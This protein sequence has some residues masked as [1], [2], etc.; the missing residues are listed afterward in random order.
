MQNIYDQEKFFEGYKNLRKN[1]LG[2]NQAL[3]QPALLSLIDTFSNK[4]V[5]DIGCGFGDFCRY[6]R[7]QGAS[8]VLGID[9]SQNMIQDAISN[10]H[11]SATHYECAPIETYQANPRQFDLIISSLALHYV[12]DLA[13]VFKKI[14]SWLKQDGL[15]IFSVEHPI[16]TQ[17]NSNL[18]YRDEGLFTQNWF[19]D[20]VEKYHRTLSTYLNGLLEN[21]FQINKVLEPM[22]TDAQIQENPKLE[23]HKIRPPI[24]VVSAS[25]KD[26][27]NH[28]KT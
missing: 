11:D 7:T 4:K 9:P 5:L 25:K 17:N 23:I 27:S 8:Y 10:T 13:P 16:C 12:K 28:A 6:A 26:Q 21:G 19:V 1:N 20:G 22:P 14:H 2:F 3:E 18:P 15:F 24:L